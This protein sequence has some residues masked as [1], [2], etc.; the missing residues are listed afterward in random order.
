MKYL[1]VTVEGYTVGDVCPTHISLPTQ[2]SK[3]DYRHKTM[4]YVEPPLSDQNQ[5]KRLCQVNKQFQTRYNLETD[6][7]TVFLPKK[8]TVPYVK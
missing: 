7:L 2:S 4:T 3:Y 6:Y 5:Y 8:Y 1:A